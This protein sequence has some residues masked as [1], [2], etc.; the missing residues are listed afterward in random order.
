MLPKERVAA[1]FRLEPTDRIPIYVAGFSSR[2]ASYLLGREAYVGGGAQWFRESVALWNGPDAHAEFEARTFTD[3]CDLCEEQDLDLVRTLY[4]RWSRKPVRRIDETTFEYGNGEV[5]HY[6]PPTEVFGCVAGDRGPR[7][8][9]EVR[10]AA[11]RELREAEAYGPTEADFPDFARSVERF[12]ATRA[13]PGTGVGIGIPREPAWLEATVTD[14]DAVGMLLDAAVLRAEKNAPVMARMGLP[15]CFGGSDFAGNAGPMYSPRTFHDLMLPRLQRIS[16][17]CR[18]AGVYHMF[19]S[20]GNLWPVAQDLF[21]A[22]GVHAFYEVDRNY[23]E[24]RAVRRAFPRLV[25]VGGVR[26][27]VVH[28]GT[29]EEVRRE[30]RSALQDAKDLGGCVVGISNQVVA[31]TPPENIRALMETLHKER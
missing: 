4:W 26:S 28:R 16:A 15:Y 23:M 11:E 17:A 1:A 19:A 13:V 25:L 18:K 8:L 24:F 9:E 30:V 2:A 29:V 3:A 10:S 31:P 14:P 7:T 12:G 27:S 6:D 22:S 21:G 5:W 20:D